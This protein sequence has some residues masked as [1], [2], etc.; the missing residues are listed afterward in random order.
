MYSTWIALKNQPVEE[1]CIT[2]FMDQREYLFQDKFKHPKIMKIQ[3]VH[4][5]ISRKND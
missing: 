1:K 2:S 4:P 5:K 3:Q